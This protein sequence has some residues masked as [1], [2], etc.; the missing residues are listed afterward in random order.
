MLPELDKPTLKEMGITLMGDMIAILRYAKNVVD[1]TTCKKLLVT[2][3]NSPPLIKSTAKPQVKKIMNIKSSIKSAAIKK[4]KLDPP[5]LIKNTNSIVKSLKSASSSTGRPPSAAAKKVSPLIGASKLYSDYIDTT[6]KPKVSQLK[7]KYSSDDDDT[8]FHDSGSNKRSKNKNEDEDDVESYMPIV[9]VRQPIM[10]QVLKRPIQ[11]KQTV[12]HRLGDS[13]V[14]STTN[15][16]SLAST[17]TP[18]FTVTGI[19]KDMRSDS[20]FGRLGN[21]KREEI[22]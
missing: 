17:F 10:D 6:T 14:S 15:I 1:E 16:D 2:T 21:K 3:E 9:K 7:R 12:F 20:V 5:K 11:P 19:G 22:V 4:T 8:W 13:M 18:A